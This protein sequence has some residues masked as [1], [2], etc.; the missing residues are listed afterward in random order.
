MF[1]RSPHRFRATGPLGPRARSRTLLAAVLML[2]TVTTATT[3]QAQAGVGTVRFG[4]EGNGAVPTLDFTGGPTLAFSSR[5]L[6]GFGNTSVIAGADARW[7]TGNYSGQGMVYGPSSTAG[8]VL[9]LR[10][11]VASGFDLFLDRALFGGFA[12]AARSVSYRLFNDDYSQSTALGTVLTGTTTPGSALFAQGGWGNVVR[13]QFTESDATT[14]QFTRG[15]FDVGIQDVAY[16]V[17][18]PVT[19]VPEPTPILLI[20]TGLAFLVRRAAPRRTSPS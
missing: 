7:W 13:L 3:A 16:R 9:E 15:P 1:P 12:N 6:S 19:A 5:V 10:F 11:E 14:G 4:G 20:A 8:H 18:A 2:A 17:A